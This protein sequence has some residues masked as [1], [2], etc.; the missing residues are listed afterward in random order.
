MLCLLGDTAAPHYE[1]IRAHT[2]APSVGVA[3]SI[4]LPED[5]K[6][7]AAYL[8]AAQAILRR[9]PDARASADKPKSATAV[10]LP[11]RRPIPRP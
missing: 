2:L 7:A 8:E 3:G 10:P 9:A 6:A 5:E 1:A 4:D 11:R